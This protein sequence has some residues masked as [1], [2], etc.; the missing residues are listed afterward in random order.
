MSRIT[1]D[2]GWP[3]WIQSIHGRRRVTSRGPLP[4]MTSIG[5]ASTHALKSAIAAWCSPTWSCTKT[6][7]GLPAD[8]A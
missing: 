3:E 1:A 4:P 7:I 6:A 5:T 2:S 8:L